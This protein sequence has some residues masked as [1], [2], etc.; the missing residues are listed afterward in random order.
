MAPKNK[1]TREEMIAAALKIVRRNGAGSLTAKAIADE[2]GISTRPVFTC[3][4]TMDTVKNE[5]RQA[6]EEIYNGYIGEGLKEK[7]PFFG[8]GHA[9]HSCCKGGTGALQ[10]AVFNAD[11]RR[12]QRSISVYGA[13]PGNSKRLACKNI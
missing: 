8:S 12:K 1:F 6:A 10:T 11:S 9:V 5:V 7:I 4:G 2:L 3:F 13:L